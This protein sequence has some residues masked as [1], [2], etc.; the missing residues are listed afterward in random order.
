M[1]TFPDF[2][3]ISLDAAPASVTFADWRKRFEAQTGRTLAESVSKTVASA[4]PMPRPAPTADPSGCN[5]C[6]SGCRRCTA[7]APR[8]SCS[9]ATKAVR[10]RASACRC[11]PE[12]RMAT[13]TALIAEDEPLL[14][15][16]LRA[17]LARLWPELQ[18]RSLPHGSL[19][20]TWRG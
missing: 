6:V 17:D 2:T 16:A 1:K 14:A 9:R 11:K 15:G 7:T 4:W 20:V 8:C 18:A 5:R 13:A 10:W 19:H 3:K 12:H